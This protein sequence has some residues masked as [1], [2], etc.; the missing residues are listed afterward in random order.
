MLALAFSGGKDSMACL[1][2][3]R[4]ELEC[5]IYVDTGFAYPETEALVR[6]AETMLPVH[7]VKVD[8]DGQNREHGIPSDVVPVDWTLLGQQFTTKKAATIQSYLSCCYENL[9]APLNAKAKELGVTHLVCGQRNEEGHKSP[10][11][12]GAVVDG[13]VRL[14]PIEH[15]SKAQVFEY[16]ASKMEI[17][18]HYALKHS[19]LDCYDCTAFR[20]ES[21]DRIAWMRSAHPEFHAAYEARMNHLDTAL[22]EAQDWRA[23]G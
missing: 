6:Y 12:D 11:R 2:L 23:H 19:S 17:P 8:R 5:A 22:R 7:R 14:H 1:H 9:S 13:I 21:H 10:S 4:D 3:M 18:A 16:L 20:K 15:W